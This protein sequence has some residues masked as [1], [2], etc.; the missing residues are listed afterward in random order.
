M[1]DTLWQTVL[2]VIAWFR[3]KLPVYKYLLILLSPLW[4]MP[5]WHQVAHATAI[6]HGI[7]SLN[8]RHF[9]TG[10]GI[11]HCDSMKY[12]LMLHWITMEYA[13]FRI[14]IRCAVPYMRH[15]Y[16]DSM[17]YDFMLHWIKME[18]AVSRMKM[19]QYGTAQT[20]YC[21]TYRTAQFL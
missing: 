17:K 12:D 9:H 7:I 14:K 4:Q 2:G 8:A 19:P 13:R 21:I 6:Q 3:P 1:V 10:Y 18:Y 16:T 15:F 5:L 11:F 20:L